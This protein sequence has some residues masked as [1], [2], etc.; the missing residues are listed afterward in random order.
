MLDAG[1]YDGSGLKSV[2]SLFG[3]GRGD[4][5][6]A[7]GGQ[8]ILDSLFGAKVGGVIDFI[9]RMAGVRTDSASS[10]LALAAPLVLHVLGQQRAT[11]GP[12]PS[13]LGS[14]L[15]EQRS[16]LAGLVP[17][18]LSSLLGWTGLTSGVSEPGRARRARPRG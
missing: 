9:A 8:G 17:A 4:A 7:G 10:L 15:G 13:A 6:G 1:K 16:V 2:T 3:G 14:L 18:G 11:I 12:T 5:R